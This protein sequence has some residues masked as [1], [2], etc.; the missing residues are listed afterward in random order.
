MLWAEDA[1]LPWVPAWTMQGCGQMKRIWRVGIVKDTTKPMLGLHG[2]HVASR[3]LPNVEIAALVDSNTENLEEAME[4]TR[5]KRRYVSCMEMLD[6]EELDIIVLC[7]RHPNDHFG[8]IK[9]AAEKGVHVY[10]EKPLTVSLAEADHIGEIAKE[11]HI[12]I[13][14]AHPGRY[15]LAFRAMKRTFV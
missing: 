10:C 3:G 4:T 5:A 1:F 12:K 6:E 13:C 9:A 7:S 14:M 8:Q 2:L 15:G 11:H